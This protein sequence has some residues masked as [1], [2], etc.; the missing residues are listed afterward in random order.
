MS[1]YLISRIHLFSQ[2]K[3]FAGTTSAQSF[4]CLCQ[5]CRSHLQGLLG[6]LRSVLGCIM[7]MST[8]QTLVTGTGE[9]LSTYLPA[10][11]ISLVGERVGRAS[12]ASHE[13]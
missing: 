5:P 13:L 4:Y 1:L 8:R 11:I 12:L 6:S 9:N 2:K 7:V 10:N 3:V